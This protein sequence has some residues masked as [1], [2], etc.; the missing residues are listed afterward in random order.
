MAVVMLATGCA[1]VSAP[2]YSRPNTT[3]E[4][5]LADVKRCANNGLLISGLIISVVLFPI[6]L[7]AG[8]PMAVVAGEKERS[9]MIKTG[10]TY[11]ESPTK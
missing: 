7:V 4:E 6:G 1:T 11:S 8:I 5:R 10:Y 9:C 2:Y 3:E